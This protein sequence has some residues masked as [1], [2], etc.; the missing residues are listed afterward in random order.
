MDSG[1][2]QTEQPTGMIRTVF[3]PP[4]RRGDVVDPARPYVKS[5]LVTRTVVGIVGIGLPVLL[6]IA[7]AF[8]GGSV[9]MRGSLSAYYHT[10]ARDVFVGGL[11]MVGVLLV[12]Y[13]S[14]SPRTW[15]FRL[16]LVAG[17]AVLLVAFVPTSRLG[18]PAGDCTDSPAPAG[19][20][21]VQQWLGETLATRIHFAC[22]LIFIVSLAL[23]SF[24][25]A[26]ERGYRESPAMTTFQYACGVLII[27]TVLTVVVCEVFDVSGI[28]VPGV[29]LLT[30][31]YLGEVVSVLLFGAAWLTKGWSLRVMLNLTP[32]PPAPDTAQPDST[33]PAPIGAQAAAD[34]P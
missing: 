25:F 21:P 31:L 10:S 6:I 13:L 34:R 9:E 2:H 3:R 26:R 18:Q 23:I 1:S 27:L 29:G 33:Q 30:P 4:D 17:F 14:G 22:A 5:Y 12:T 8:I 11:C 20:A 19:C 7:E 15:G 16:S 32:P 24:S 28:D